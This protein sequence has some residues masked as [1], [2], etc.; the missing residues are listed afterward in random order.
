M[1]Q[2]TKVLVLGGVLGAVL[3]MSAAWI[4]LRGAEEE[5]GAQ[6]APPKLRAGDVVRLGIAILGV[7]RQIATLGEPQG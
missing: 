7:L 4:F 1:K 5:A 3:G 6:A 2:R